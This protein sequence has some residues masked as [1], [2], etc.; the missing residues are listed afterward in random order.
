MP[1]D[2]AGQQ[3]RVALDVLHAADELITRHAATITA[4]VVPDRGEQSLKVRGLFDGTRLQPVQVVLQFIHDDPRPILGFNEQLPPVFALGRLTDR[5]NPRS[6][7]RRH[8]KSPIPVSQPRSCLLTPAPDVL[9][10][11]PMP[12]LLVP[13]TLSV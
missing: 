5:V 2:N 11:T 10:L 7:S 4:E 9:E 6:V 8:Y 3:R 1:F 12:D 13:K